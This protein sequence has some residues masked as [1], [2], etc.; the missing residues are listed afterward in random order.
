MSEIFERLCPYYMSYGM[1]Y[2]QYW[3]GDPWALK[4]YRDAKHLRD[5][6]ENEMMW[7]NGFYTLNALSVVIGNAFAKK[8]SAPRK[9]LEKALDV[10]PKTEA[11]EA[12]EQEQKQKA[13]IMGLSAWKTQ[14]DAAK[15]R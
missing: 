5:R 8:G 11:E 3:Y 15:K 4:A 10:F 9:Y 13:L 2:D 7:L 6:H 12:A 1:T 14:F